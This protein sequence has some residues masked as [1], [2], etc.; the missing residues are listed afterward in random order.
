VFHPYAVEGVPYYPTYPG[1]SAF[2]QPGCPPMEDPRLHA[3]QS[4]RHR[5]HS[6]D[7]RHGNT[8]SEDWDIDTSKTRCKDEM[9]I[10]REG[11]QTGDR[12]KKTSRSDRRK[13]GTVV[14]QNI[15]YIAKT[16]HSSGSGSYS[17]S[18][19]E[20]D[21]DKEVHKSV[22]SSKR[23]GSGKA[24]LKRLNS[25]DKEETDGGH[26]QA[27]QNYLLKG[28]DE[29]RHAINQNQ[30]ELEKGDHVRR[31]KHVAAKDPLDLTGNSYPSSDVAAVNGQCYSNNNLEKKLFHNV[32]DYSIMVEHRVNDAVNIEGNA[33]DM[34][35]EFPNVYTKEGKRQI[36]NYQPAELSLLPERGVDKG[37]M[38]YDCALDYK[39]QAQDVG[40]SSQDKKNEGVLAHHTKPRSKMLDKEQKSKPTPS[41]SDRK[42]TVGTIRRGKPNKPSPLDEAR[43]RAERLRNYKADLQK[44][45]KEKVLTQV[46]VI[47]N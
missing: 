6:M 46:E 5:R 7:N 13:S 30:F 9:D 22:K 35:S 45:K 25:T 10:E 47:G 38:R 36:S 44:L 19:T 23:R 21:E 42:K 3:D 24:S 43:A 37:S 14:I 17:D 15:N 27:F 26:W 18:A 8:D 16:E 11:L 29:D 34:D 4:V 31:N 39:M 41:S 12:R 32:N 40:G 1:N 20:T 28:V 2:T 33:I